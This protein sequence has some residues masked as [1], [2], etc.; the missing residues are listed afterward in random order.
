MTPADC[1]SCTC[2]AST[3]TGPGYSGYASGELEERRVTPS[4]RLSFPLP[5]GHTRPRTTQFNAMKLAPSLRKRLG[6][7]SRFISIPGPAYLLRHLNGGDPQQIPGS[8]TT[9][10]VLLRCTGPI[11]LYTALLL[12]FKRY[13]ACRQEDFF[14]ISQHL[15]RGLQDECRSFELAVMYSSSRHMRDNARRDQT[16]RGAR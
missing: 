5:W 15:P 12:R 10:P 4:L 13:R 11:S 6:C 9:R 3:M 14:N 2:P 7:R 16:T 1:R 8:T